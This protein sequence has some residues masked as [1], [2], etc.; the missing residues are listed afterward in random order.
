MAMYLSRIPIFTIM[1]L[2]GWSSNAFLHCIRKQVKEFSTGVSKKMI[3]HEDFF[4]VPSASAK[5]PE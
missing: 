5:D 2:V 3:I 1:L 4:T